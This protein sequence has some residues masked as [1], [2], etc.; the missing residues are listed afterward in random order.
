MKAFNEFHPA[1][2]GG[3]GLI[4]LLTEKLAEAIQPNNKGLRGGGCF[5]RRAQANRYPDFGLD[6]APAFPPPLMQS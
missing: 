3:T 2:A 4:L 5:D 6:L 1:Q